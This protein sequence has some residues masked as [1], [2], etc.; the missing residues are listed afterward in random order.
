MHL[1]QLRQADLNLLIVFAIVAEERNVSRAAT[2]LRLS[3]PAVSRALQRARDMFHDDLV[4][5]T[6][7]S[8]EL[9]PLGT[10]LLRELEGTLPRLDYLLSGKGFDPNVEDVTFRLS[11]TDYATQMVCPHLCQDFVTPESKV[12]FDFIA[13]NDAVFDSM[14]H[15][16]LDLVLN[17]DDGN[18]PRTLAREIL[19]E[20][21]FV[22]V[23]SKDFAVA[24]QFTLSQYLKAEHVGISIF[25][26]LQSLPDQTLAQLGESRHC[27]LRLPYFD[28]G[29]RAVIGTSLVVTVPKRIATYEATDAALKI[30]K[31]PTEMKGFR[32]QM[33]WHPRMN[34]DA[35]HV[36]L[37]S[38]LRQ[39][40]KQVT[41]SKE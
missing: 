30:V 18:A 2:R 21:E 39:I 11:C 20:E 37:R 38:V 16:R 3:Q 24:R 13:W 31:A 32:Y 35:A 26:G 27:P 36:W 23:V 14:K 15:G 22:C 7:A 40:G 29:I 1:A 10:R 34:T 4:V 25:D 33:V 8:F 19:F 9:T 12:T 5:R 17:A 41:K 6:N 28:S